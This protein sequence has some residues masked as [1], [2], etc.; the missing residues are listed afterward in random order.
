MKDWKELKNVWEKKYDPSTLE[1]NN[2][3]HRK[4]FCIV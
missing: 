3:T 2:K 4:V 1:S